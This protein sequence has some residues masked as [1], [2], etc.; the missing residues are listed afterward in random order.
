MAFLSLACVQAHGVIFL[1]D[2]RWKG[3]SL[4]G[5]CH[6]WVGGPE[7][8]MKALSQVMKINPVSRVPLWFLLQFLPQF[9]FL[10]LH[11]R[12][13]LVMVTAMSV[14]RT[15]SSITAPHQPL[16]VLSCPVPAPFTW[17][18]CEQ[19]SLFLPFGPCSFFYPSSVSGPSQ[20]Q[21]KAPFAW[22]WKNQ[23]VR[24]PG[25]VARQGN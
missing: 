22:S 18:F 10:L 25:S 19:S 20:R 1:T 17:L 14:T 3:P 11:P 4:C 16:P 13:V 2:D 8:T 21:L 7:V 12:L 15:K 6:P 5:L 9:P 24:L 23:R